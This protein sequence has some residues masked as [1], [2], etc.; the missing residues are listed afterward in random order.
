MLLTLRLVFDFGLAALAA[1]F[2]FN[3]YA[4]YR[5]ATGT[6][7]QRLLAGARNSATMLW[8]KFCIILA[9][10]VANLDQIADAIGQ[11]EAKQYIADIL[12]NPKAVAGV[13]LAITAVTMIARARTLTS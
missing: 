11:P 12:G 2:V 4:G 7:W 13:M 9:A 1:Y 3:V 10:V 6:V 5:A 8:S